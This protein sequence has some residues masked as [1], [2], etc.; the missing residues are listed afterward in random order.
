MAKKPKT[1]R[2]L[3][4][5]LQSASDVLFPAELGERKVSV[6]SSDSEGDTPLHVM[7]WRRDKHAVELLISA[8]AD[9]NA[10]GDMGETPLHVAISQGD[11][12]IV[13]VILN[14][15]AKTDIRSEFNQTAIEKAKAKGGAIGKL[16]KRRQE[17]DLAK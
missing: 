12:E 2:S 5:V 8:G 16:L 9:V 13:R 3:E 4:D 7:V 10:V 6:T 14:A 1:R 15:D 11:E 17:A